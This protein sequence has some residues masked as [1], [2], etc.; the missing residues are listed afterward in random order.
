MIY[1]S[2]QWR[3]GHHP[4]FDYAP[5]TLSTHRSPCL[6]PPRPSCYGDFLHC[7]R[8]H[9]SFL[10]AELRPHTALS[11]HAPIPCCHESDCTPTCTGANIGSPTAGHRHDFLVSRFLSASPPRLVVRT[12]Q[13]LQ[14]LSHDR[15]DPFI[16]SVCCLFIIHP[17]LVLVLV[18]F[19]PSLIVVLSLLYLHCPNTRPDDCHLP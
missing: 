19:G 14:P 8:P 11:L 2:R 4:D 17:F 12:V 7:R 1:P 13:D 18:H 15:S 16:C 10:G 9:P 3:V 6:C 5:S